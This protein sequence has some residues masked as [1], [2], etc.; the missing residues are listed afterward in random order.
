L[1]GGNVLFSPGRIA[2]GWKG[3]LIGSVCWSIASTAGAQASREDAV[4]KPEGQMKS[5]AEL[6]RERGIARCREDRGVDCDTPAGQKEW[7][8]QERPITDEE[9]AAAAGARRAAERRQQQRRMP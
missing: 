6:Q 5:E 1:I 4:R 7:I 9:R 8:Q 3:V 2:M